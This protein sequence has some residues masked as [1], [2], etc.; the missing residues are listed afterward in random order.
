M[1]KVIVLILI[2]I[3]QSVVAQSFNQTDAQGRK[4]GKWKKVYS[5][6]KTRYEGQFD[7]GM[8]VGTFKYYNA[9]GKLTTILTYSEG[10]HFAVCK[11]YYVKG[12]LQA[13][14]YYR[15]KKK[16]SVWLYYSEETQKVVAEEHYKNG[17]KNGPWRIFFD[18]GNLSSEVF[19]KDGKKDGPWKEFFQDGTPRLSANYKNDKLD[20]DYKIYNV[21]GRIIKKGKYVKGKADGEWI[22]Y[23]D[24]GKITKKD[25]LVMDW[26]KEEV[27]YKNGEPVKIVN[28][29][30]IP[31][32]KEGS[33]KG[34]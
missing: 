28:H 1:N 22:T 14:G 26:L 27:F 33:K 25:I 31:K 29:N 15:D 7:K 16:D 24:S 30:E 17:V 6:G 21:G 8:P 32:K 4:T 13:S 20:G 5:N 2:F 12:K 10:G 19:W 3:A 34:K 11:M 18:N 9:D 23:D